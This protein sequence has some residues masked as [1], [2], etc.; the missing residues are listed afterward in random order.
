MVQVLTRGPTLWCNDHDVN[1]VE[2]WVLWAAGKRVH[3][4]VGL[5]ELGSFVLSVDPII[6]FL[7]V[8]IVQIFR[9]EIIGL[10]LW[11]KTGTVDRKTVYLEK[12]GIFQVFDP[13]RV[14]NKKFF[15]KCFPMIL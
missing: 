6:N 14:L 12:G 13:T 3:Y 8:S 4:E 9:I 10:R 2:H 1:V 15:K 7:H 5:L 11:L